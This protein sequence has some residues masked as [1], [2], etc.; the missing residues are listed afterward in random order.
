MRTIKLTY[1][2]TLALEELPETVAAI[3]FF[4]GIH[5]GH[6]N[7]IKTAVSE[8]KERNME[9]AVI[10]FHPHP[11]V[12]LKKDVQH[13]QYITPLKEKQEVLQKMDVDR[14]YIITFNKELSSLSPQQFIDHFIIGLNIKHLV[15]GFDYSFGHKGKGNMNNI[16]E[17]TREEF[18]FTTIKKVELDDEKVSSTK[19]REL[20]HSGKVEAVKLLL[21]R[22]LTVSGIV[23]EGDKRG[24]T[25]GY[26]TANLQLDQD[27]LLPKPGIYAVKV[28]YKNEAYE[29]MASLGT[30]PTFTANRKDLSLEVNILDY[31]NDLYG[32]ELQMEWCKFIRDEL[33]FD[34][35]EALIDQIADDEKVIRAYFSNER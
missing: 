11:S 35:V 31:Q 14:L 22:P 16:A 24:R 20:L 10:T 4:D 1:P 8:A 18:T 5:L 29:G 7:V 3:G 2:H 13:V 27:A 23:I 17:Y 19:I 28:I 26:P 12:V 34:N 32:E 33:K 6:Q 30:N 25:I 15:A 21:G 9:S